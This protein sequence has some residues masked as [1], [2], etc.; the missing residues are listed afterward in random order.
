L[1]ALEAVSAF[2]PPRRVPIEDLA[3]PAGITERDLMIFRRYFGLREVRRYPNGSA[4]GLA[5]A[6]AGRL[7]AL[8]GQ[9]PQVRFV[10][11][12]LTIESVESDSG[13]ALEEVRAEL[14]LEHAVAFTV[15][16][17]GCAS[18][19]LAVDLAG[20]LLAQTGDPG[21]RALVLAGEKA[22]T[23][24]AQT[25]PGTTVMGEASAAMLVRHGG[26]TDRVLAYATHTLGR[27][28]AGLFLAGPLVAEF[29]AVYLD[30]LAEV[31]TAALDH[32]GTDLGE[33]ALVLPHNVNRHSWVRLCR[34]LG[35]PVERVLLDNIPTLGHCFA[36]DPFLNYATAVGS[37]RLRAGDQYRM[38]SV[39]LGATFSAMVLQH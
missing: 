14:G 35:Y 3:G 6:A 16:Q 24:K 12:A 19:L 18:G 33:L 39:G 25:I 30:G 7:D 1:T 10:I 13:R 38:A 8:R 26:S 15:T 22:L 21:A 37:G 23:T 5:L 20:R 4:A 29:Q 17:H 31:I 28:N 34:Q 9:E 2:I 11:Q 32:A 36:A 27:F